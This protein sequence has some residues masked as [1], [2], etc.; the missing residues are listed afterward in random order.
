MWNFHALSWC[1]W[2]CGAHSNLE[3]NHQAL[4]FR[5]GCQIDQWLQFSL[6]PSQTAQVVRNLLWPSDDR[7]LFCSSRNAILHQRHWMGS[8][9]APG[10]VHLLKLVEQ[11]WQWIHT[12]CRCRQGLHLRSS[13]ILKPIDFFHPMVRKVRKMC[14]FGLL[15]LRGVN[16][17][18][19]FVLCTQMPYNGN[20]LRVYILHQG[21]SNRKF[22]CHRFGLRLVSWNEPSALWSPL[23]KAISLDH[24]CRSR[25]S[26][27][28]SW[29]SSWMHCLL[30]RIFPIHLLWLSNQGSVL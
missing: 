3:R 7:I 28:G 30:S 16:L 8:S 19:R 5:W 12:P 10:C 9:V 27:F 24:C 11:I 1:R 17:L 26:V 15:L 14:W 6:H 23:A 25:S 18:G 29:S 13:W 21:S 20:H 4:R 22:C 2:V